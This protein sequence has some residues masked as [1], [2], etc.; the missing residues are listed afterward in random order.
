LIKAGEELT[1]DYADFLDQHA[2]PFTCRC[3]SENCRKQIQG[4]PHN[5]IDS[6]EKN[7]R[8]TM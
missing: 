4:S 1:L 8:D 5:T 2:E 3:G 7:S 6:R